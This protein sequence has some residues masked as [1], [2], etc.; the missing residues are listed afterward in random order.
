M[1]PKPGYKTTEFWLSLAA[2]LVSVAFASGAVPSEGPWLQLL[3]A[4]GTVLSA[5]GY[6]AARVKTKASLRD[7]SIHAPVAPYG[8]GGNVTLSGPE[9]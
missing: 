7:M 8:S 5:L 9:A 1:D 6:T 3:G 4:A 2:S